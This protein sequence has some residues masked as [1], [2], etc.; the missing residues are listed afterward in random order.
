MDI[1]HKVGKEI[2]LDIKYEQDWSTLRYPTDAL[3]NL[4][5]EQIWRGECCIHFPRFPNMKH[6]SQQID[7]TWHFKCPDDTNS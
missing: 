2:I 7:S 3:K 4:Y 5:N 1:V 6:L